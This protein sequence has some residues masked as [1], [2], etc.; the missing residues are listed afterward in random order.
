MTTLKDV[1]YRIDLIDGMVAVF[2]QAHSPL[3]CTPSP[4]S[5]RASPALPGPPPARRPAP[6]PPR[7][8]ATRSGL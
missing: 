5:A 8:A 1:V 2:Q 4:G 3:L 6:W 7:S